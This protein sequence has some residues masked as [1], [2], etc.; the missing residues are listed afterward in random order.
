MGLPFL[1]FLGKALGGFLASSAAP[2]VLTA[3]ASLVGTAVDAAARKR[4]E[5]NNS[6]AGIR[7]RAEAAGFNPLLFVGPGTGT[8]AGYAPRMGANFANSIAL[9]ADQMGNQRQ[10]E[11]QKAQLEMQNARLNERVRKATLTPKVR[12]QYQNGRSAT[13]RGKGRDSDDVDGPVLSDAQR[14]A[15][16]AAAGDGKPLQYSDG[17]APALKVGGVQFYGSGA[18]SSGE[19]IEDALGEGPLSWLAT[20][21]IP[22]DLAGAKVKD[23][24]TSRRNDKLWKKAMRAQAEYRERRLLKQQRKFTNE[25]LRGH[26]GLPGSRSGF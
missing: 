9:A 14:L 20:L 3:G 1:G 26:Y 12:G 15:A 25:P 6:P 23:I 5:Y 17:A 13:D 10:L 19:Q 2:A 24:V 18:T 4:D 8:G 22:G 11:M 21:A 16:S 7:A